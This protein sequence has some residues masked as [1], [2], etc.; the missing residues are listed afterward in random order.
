MIAL[1][2]N[3][4]YKTKKFTTFFFFLQTMASTVE[5]E[6]DIKRITKRQ[7]NS[8]NPC[9]NNARDLNIE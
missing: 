6:L 5:L 8:G 9:S 1:F 4:V 3:S 2:T 7:T